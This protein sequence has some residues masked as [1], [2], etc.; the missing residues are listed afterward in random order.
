MNYFTWLFRQIMKSFESWKTITELWI[1]ITREFVVVNIVA[2]D[3]I[4][5]DI[6]VLEKDDESISPFFKRVSDWA[7]QYTDLE[8]LAY[9]PETFKMHEQIAVSYVSIEK[10]IKGLETDKEQYY[11]TWGIATNW[12]Y[13]AQDSDGCLQQ[14]KSIAKIPKQELIKIKTETGETISITTEKAKELWFNI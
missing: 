4:K 8:D 10:A 12:D 13:I 11:Y 7:I 5:W 6:V 14:F 1:D 2:R 3:F 9:A